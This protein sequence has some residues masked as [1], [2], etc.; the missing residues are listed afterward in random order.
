MDSGLVARGPFR[1]CDQQGVRDRAC[2][3]RM[4]PAK[5]RALGDDDVDGGFVCVCVVRAGNNSCAHKRRR[6]CTHTHSP[7]HMRLGFVMKF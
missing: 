4:L 7:M 5:P 2:C 6:K 3:V 1:L